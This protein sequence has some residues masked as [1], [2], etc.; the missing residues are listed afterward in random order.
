MKLKTK[1]RSTWTGKKKKDS[2]KFPCPSNRNYG[3]LCC[4]C[5]CGQTS[6]Q[7]ILPKHNNIRMYQHISSSIN[8]INF[9]RQKKNIKLRISFSTDIFRTFSL[10]FSSLRLPSCTGDFIIFVLNSI[11]ISVFFQLR[12]KNYYKEKLVA[13]DFF[14]IANFSIMME[15]FYFSNEKFTINWF[16]LPTFNKRRRAMKF[17]SVLDMVFIVWINSKPTFATLHSASYTASVAL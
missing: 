11:K 12:K 3:K 15:N 1:M 2:N 13:S 8:F 9:P 7:Y 5:E 4:C 17:I 6:E 10:W 14:S 16:F